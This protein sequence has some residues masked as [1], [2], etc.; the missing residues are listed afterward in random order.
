MDRR[1]FLKKGTGVV[2]LGTSPRATRGKTSLGEEA[3]GEAPHAAAAACPRHAYRAES[4]QVTPHELQLAQ[5]WFAAIT[6][7]ER[8]SLPSEKW[9]D[10]WLGATLP[11]SFRYGGKEGNPLLAGWQFH[12]GEAREDSYFQQR[13]FIWA[14]AD[15]GL[16]FRWRLKRFANFPA[17]EWTLWFENLGNMDT[18]VLEE[19][20]DLSLHLNHSEKRGTVHCSWGPRRALQTRRLVAL[21][22]VFALGHWWRSRL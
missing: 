4:S 22:R 8:G 5:E 7:D 12:E 19:I 14:D 10:Q 17:I 21:F 15:T 13:E 3:L 20:Q 11:F 6:P 9:F 16:Q 2:A 1:D 18:R